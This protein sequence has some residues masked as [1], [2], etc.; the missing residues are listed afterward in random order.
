MDLIQINK[1]LNSSIWFNVIG[2]G[3]SG[4]LQLLS[5]GDITVKITDFNGLKVDVFQEKGKGR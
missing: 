2:V 4:M 1:S 3:R 5:W